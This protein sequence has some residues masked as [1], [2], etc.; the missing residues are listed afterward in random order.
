MNGFKKN[1]QGEGVG[2][3]DFNDKNVESPGVEYYNRVKARFLEKK[4]EQD[5][6]IEVKQ[7]EVSIEPDKS[8]PI[9]KKRKKRKTKKDENN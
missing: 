2:L 7:E 6:V 5:N 1:S 4:R 9:K 8:K 3:I